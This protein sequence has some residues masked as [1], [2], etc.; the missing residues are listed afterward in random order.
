MQSIIPTLLHKITTITFQEAT[1]KMGKMIRNM[2]AGDTSV[3]MTI[4]VEDLEVKDD[5]MEIGIT[6]HGNQFSVLHVI[7][8]DT[9]TQI[10]HIKI[11]PT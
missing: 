1:K 8:K 2:T 10:V 5:S 11:G 7:R 9:D 3:G 6:N 4:I